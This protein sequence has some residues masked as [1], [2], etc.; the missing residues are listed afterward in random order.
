VVAV[1]NSHFSVS[2]YRHNGWNQKEYVCVY[3]FAAF[4]YPLIRR[5]FKQGDDEAA[6]EYQAKGVRDEKEE[7][8]ACKEGCDVEEQ[9]VWW[10]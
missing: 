10:M 3:R 5:D 2:I 9:Y 1:V 7:L 6:G 8:E 4:A